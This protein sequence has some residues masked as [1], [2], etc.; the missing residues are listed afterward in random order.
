MTT[1]F[2][3]FLHE[4]LS[5]MAAT[6]NYDPSSM[7]DK[8]SQKV[9]S[10]PGSSQHWKY[11]QQ[12]TPEVRKDI[13]TKIIQ[14]IFTDNEDNTYSLSIDNVE[15]LRHAIVS[16][17]KKV[18]ET[19][20]DFKATSNTIIK[21]LADRLANK[22]LLGNVK[23]TTA[24]GEDIVLDKDVTQ[25]D[26]KNALKKALNPKS[27]LDD[28]SSDDSE[29]QKTLD[30][31]LSPEPIETKKEQ[32]YNPAR[33]Y[34]LKTYEEIPSGKLKGDIQVAYDRL[35]GMS[36]EVHSGN[37]FAKTLRNSNLPVSFVKQ[38]VDL[39]IIELADTDIEDVG[40]TKGFDETERDYM[41][42]LTKAARED[43]E[44]SSPSSRFGGEDVFG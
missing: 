40:D 6:T 21:F 8:V 24:R 18:A 31:D 32:A 14:N 36:G 34:Y 9:A 3:S 10:L 37:D 1:K 27:D 30:Q 5:E 4:M 39:D 12:L 42:R 7:G 22:E 44:K 11:L 20:S 16:A 15:D 17:I 2:D 38:L 35:S 28:E 33:D 23:Y 13:V 43:Y 19:N 29:P 41:D 25:Q 26:V